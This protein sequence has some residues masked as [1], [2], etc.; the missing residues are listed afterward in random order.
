MQQTGGNVS[1]DPN[2]KVFLTTGPDHPSG[3][4]RDDGVGVATKKTTLIKKPSLY[5]V[6][7]LN[8]DFTPMDFVVEVLEKIFNKDHVAATKIMLNV[9]RKGAGECGVYPREVAETKVIQV[10]DQ[11]R[12]RDYPLQCTMERA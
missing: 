9:H 1:M 8:D 12:K 3:D 6:L 10:G 5:R 7:I 4:E 11:A 2:T